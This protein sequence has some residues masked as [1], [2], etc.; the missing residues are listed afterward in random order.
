MWILK[1][2]YD[3][4]W[5]KYGLEKID[6]ATKTSLFD[7]NWAIALKPR[8]RSRPLR[9]VWWALD[10]VT[11]NVG[12]KD[13]WFERRCLIGQVLSMTDSSKCC[14]WDSILG[15][16]RGKK[17]NKLKM[18]MKNRKRNRSMKKIILTGNFPQNDK[19]SDLG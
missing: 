19:Q 3:Y 10:M 16:P 17:G 14:C 15:R 13:S 1:K 18:T 2:K 12:T 11:K 4:W 6:R 8:R 7:R 9:L 5:K